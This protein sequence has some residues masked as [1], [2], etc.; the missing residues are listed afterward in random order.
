MVG[1]GLLDM[2]W[3]DLGDLEGPEP[4]EPAQLEHHVVSI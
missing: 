2:G 4:D 3:L 1:V